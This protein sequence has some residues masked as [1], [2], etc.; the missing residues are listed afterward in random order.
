MA[1][2]MDSAV[3]EWQRKEREAARRTEKMEVEK[4]TS[5]EGKIW[6]G[7]AE[8]E[9]EEVADG[10]GGDVYKW[11]EGG[12][13]GRNWRM[14]MQGHQRQPFEAGHRP[15]WRPRGGGWSG[16]GGFQ[17]QRHPWNQRHQKSN[18]SN[19]PGVYGGAVIICN[20]EIKRQ[21]FEQKHFA[22][23]GYA[24]TFIKK[25]RAGMLL[26]LFEHEE[27]KLY[28]V[29][30]ATSDGALN[31]LPNA[32]AS[33]C[34]LR[35]AQ[36]LFRR[37][38]FCKPLTEA[39]FSDVI[40]GHCLQPQRSFFG[41][42]YQQV[43]NLVDLFS[44]RMIRLQPYQKPKSKVLWDYKISLARTGREFRLYTHSNGFSRPPS[45]FCNNRISLPHIPFMH[46]KHN[47]QHPA[48]KH[49]SPL[50]P[51]PKP[52]VFKSPD[53]IEK[54]KPDNADY[55]PLELDDCN[56]DSDGNQSALMGTVSFH[57][58]MENNINCEDQVP[59]PFNGK[60]TADNRCCSPVLNQRFVS[61]SETGQNNN[62]IGISM[63]S[64]APE[65]TVHRVTTTAQHSTSRHSLTPNGHATALS[66][67]APAP[68][69]PPRRKHE[70]APTPATSGYLALGVVVD[71]LLPPRPLL[72]LGWRGDGEPI[73]TRQAALID[74]FRCCSEK[75]N[76]K[77]L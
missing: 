5:G 38:W 50:H 69:T 35:P 51:C 46:A 74:S 57:S 29:F 13:I 45:M 34:K 1:M 76:P 21:F 27:R 70:T 22:L 30:E 63:P 8:A 7:G 25:I 12:A 67:S 23:P 32:C 55:I 59:K 48:H 11:E 9:E 43:L 10:G 72:I 31:I 42:S 16:R 18:I 36:V 62:D 61:E 3:E 56:S 64:G 53:I 20:H 17:F 26:F 40:K 75:P 37:V 44:S 47:G 39:E 4:E 66:A 19:N 6:R 49:E 60:H 33:L 68:T 15:F 41:I 52:M 77:L 28:G 14:Q 71:V 2:E 65:I 73:L 58:A 54:N 24:A